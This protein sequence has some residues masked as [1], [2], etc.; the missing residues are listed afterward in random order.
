MWIKIVRKRSRIQY[1]I[2]QSLVEMAPCDSSQPVDI[3]TLNLDNK[4]ATEK[5]LTQ[6]RSGNKTTLCYD[7]R[8]YQQA[9]M[10]RKLISRTPAR[11][12]CRVSSKGNPRSTFHSHNPLSL[13]DSHMSYLE[14]QL[15][16]WVPSLVYHP[17]TIQAPIPPTDCSNP[18]LPD[19]HAIPPCSPTPL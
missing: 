9:A 16:S 2:W 15:S 4:L 19:P 14:S 6:T 8:V 11:W 12:G 13:H 7:K 17:S 5:V 10:P 18:S 3:R 1:Y